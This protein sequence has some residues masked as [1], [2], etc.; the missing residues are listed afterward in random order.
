MTL[1]MRDDIGIWKSVTVGELLAALEG[2]PPGAHVVLNP[3]TDNLTVMQGEAGD[4]QNWTAVAHID[5]ATGHL[6]RAE[7]EAAA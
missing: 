7:D 2:L 6:V 5:I 4:E 3:I 1:N